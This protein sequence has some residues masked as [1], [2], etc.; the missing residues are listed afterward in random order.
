MGVCLL[1]RYKSE[2]RVHRHLDFALEGLLLLLADAFGTVH[3]RWQRTLSSQEHIQRLKQTVSENLTLLRGGVMLAHSL[4]LAS[5]ALGMGAVIEQQVTCH[6]GCLGSS[7]LFRTLGGL[8]AMGQDYQRLHLGVE[9]FS[10]GLCNLFLGPRSPRKE[11]R[12]S[13]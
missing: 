2:D 7:P 8:G 4:H 12:Q 1:G 13:R 6:N 3:L 9:T 10:P 11:A 5:F